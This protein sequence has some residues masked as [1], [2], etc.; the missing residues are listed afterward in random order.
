[1]LSSP[2]SA[3][4]TRNGSATLL[5]PLDLLNGSYAP[6][7]ITSTWFLCPATALT[8]CSHSPIQPAPSTAG[9]IFVPFVSS[10]SSRPLCWQGLDST[11]TFLGWAWQFYSPAN[12]ACPHS[13]STPWLEFPS[14]ES[15]VC[16]LRFRDFYFLEVIWLFWFSFKGLIFS[17]G[18]EWSFNEFLCRSLI[19]VD[20]T[21]SSSNLR[22]TSPWTSLM[23][24]NATS[25]FKFPASA[26]RSSTSRIR[27]SAS[28]KYPFTK[29][30][31]L[32]SNFS[33]KVFRRFCSVFP[34]R[35]CTLIF[36]S[37]LKNTFMSITGFEPHNSKRWTIA[38]H[39]LW[40]WLSELQFHS[41]VFRFRLSGKQQ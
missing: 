23:P 20:T 41:K 11:S 4:I 16:S 35:P 17:F 27:T 18:N 13:S 10:Y 24:D 2:C 37:P 39:I 6:S 19:F 14:F 32:T 26:Q 7:I 8:F 40:V 3:I 9:S 31:I 25:T 38:F 28:K 21:S 12:W 33:D 30:E 15:F 22:V 29:V 36:P 5:G 1:M 34:F